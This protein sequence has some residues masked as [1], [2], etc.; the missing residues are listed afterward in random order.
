VRDVHHV[1]QR[2][3][4]A[5]RGITVP[6]V[7]Y[8][9]SAGPEDPVGVM[10]DGLTEINVRN[11]S[12]ARNL[13]GLFAGATG[14]GGVGGSSTIASSA[15]TSRTTKSKKTIVVD[16]ENF[17]ENKPRVVKSIV[18]REIAPKKIDPNK[19]PVFK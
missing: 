19:K 5:Q 13:K 10:N 14:G 8:Q 18:I 12:M 3:N 1:G 7:V 6:E 16:P 2:Q 9:R 4:F 11:Q 17:Y 15:C